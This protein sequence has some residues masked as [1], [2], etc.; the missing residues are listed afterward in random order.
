MHTYPH[1]TVVIVIDCSN[2]DRAADF[3]CGVL[4]YQ[5]PHPQSGAY[6]MLIPPDGG[7]EILLQ[8]V[9]DPKTTKNRLHLDLRTPDLTA[10]VDRIIALGATQL[11][12]QPYIEHDWTWH[13]LADH[14]GNEF[15]ILQPPDDFPWPAKQPVHC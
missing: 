3:W 6:L 10:E 13:I 5:R 15:C 2:L 12:D 9:P 4:G 11:T 7:V 8:E 14:D 1:G